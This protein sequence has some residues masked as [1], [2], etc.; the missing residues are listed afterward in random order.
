M[1]IFELYGIAFLVVLVA[2]SVL[3]AISVPLKDASIIDMF[4]GPL[5]VAIAWVLLPATGMLAVK[6]Y[7]IT[8]LVTLWGLRLGFHL[9]TRNAGQGE[10]RRYQLWREHGGEDWWLKSYYRV[11]LLQGGI[12]L[13]VAT[14]II[15][16]FY[17]PH[18]LNFLNFLGVLVWAA[19]FIY[20]LQADVQLSQFKSQPENRGR[21][22]DQGL[23]ARSR[24]PNYFGDALQWW[25]LGL[26]AVS[27]ATW[28]AL[29]GPVVMTAVFLGLSNDVLERGM[30]KRHPEYE[31][32]ITNTPKFF[33]RLSR[34]QG[35][36]T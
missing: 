10:D 16:A 5:F 1:G 12:A 3:W 30:K 23:W 32:Y 14:P 13:A 24:H 19:G 31:R 7:L 8:L 26:V 17:R 25:G 22:L 36:R 15:A 11:Y 27:F 35:V 4:W 21:V 34:S 28:W 33:P 18:E 20:E 2:V 9:I 29:L 6:P